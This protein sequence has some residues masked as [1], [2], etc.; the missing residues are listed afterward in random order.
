MILFKKKLFVVFVLMGF[1]L[2]VLVCVEFLLCVNGSMVYDIVSNFIWLVDVGFGGLCSQGDVVQWVVDLSVGGFDDWCL[3]MVVFVNG[4]V[5]QFDYVDDGFIDIGFNNVGLNIELGYFYYVSFGN[6][7]VGLM[8]MGVFI[9]LVDLNNFI[10]LVFWMGM[11][12]ELGWGLVFFMGM[13]VQDQ[14]VVD[15]FGQVWVVC[16]GDV[17]VV[18]EFGSV[19]LVL[20]GLLVIVVCCCLL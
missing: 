9:G 4:L 19:V 17:V 15:I 14:F 20:V 5:L 16:V 11:V 1:L 6:M 12:S 3:F 13:G 2:V 7:V 8:Q 10:G 18:F